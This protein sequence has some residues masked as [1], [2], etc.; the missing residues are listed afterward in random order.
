MY[1]LI[2]TVKL[3]ISTNF[4]KVISPHYIQNFQKKSVRHYA[5]INYDQVYN[6]AFHDKLVSLL[7]NACLEK[8]GAI[9]GTSTEKN[10]PRI[11]LKI[12]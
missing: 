9:R 10:I 4:A 5:D 7:Y 1:L 6:S 3:L 12:S 2:V 8:T 11:W